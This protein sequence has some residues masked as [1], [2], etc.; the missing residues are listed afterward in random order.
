MLRQFSGEVWLPSAD[1]HGIDDTIFAL[2]FSLKDAS[3]TATRLP[4]DLRG[5]QSIAF[6][7]IH[8]FEHIFDEHRK[9][10][11]ELGDRHCRDLQHGIAQFYDC[12]DHFLTYHGFG[13]LTARMSSQ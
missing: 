6:G 7:L 1:N 8:R 13:D 12:V 9:I 10:A 11:T 3:T 2:L 5:S 4:A